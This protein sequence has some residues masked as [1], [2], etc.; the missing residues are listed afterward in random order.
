MHGQLWA[1]IRA[2]LIL[3]SEHSYK[4]LHDR[5]QEE[6]ALHLIAEK[7][8]AEGPYRSAGGLRRALRPEKRAGGDLSRYV[9]QLT[10]NA[11]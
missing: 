6:A 4:F 5:V 11:A 2:G 3:R 8:G 9:N 7:S 10:A 1:A